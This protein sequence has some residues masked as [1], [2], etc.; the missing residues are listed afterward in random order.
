MSFPPYSITN[1]QRYPQG[2]TIDGSG[3]V[4][5][6]ARDGCAVRKYKPQ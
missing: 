5:V 2:V 6:I 1:S 3:N 4:Y